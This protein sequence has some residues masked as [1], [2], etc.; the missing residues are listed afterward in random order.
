MQDCIKFVGLKLCGLCTCKIFFFSVQNDVH[1]LVNLEVLWKASASSEK[2]ISI[3]KKMCFS[4]LLSKRQNA[5]FFMLRDE[6]AIGTVYLLIGL[7]VEWS[8]QN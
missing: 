5:V 3:H 7:L 2:L 4:V 1:K 8:I 6:M